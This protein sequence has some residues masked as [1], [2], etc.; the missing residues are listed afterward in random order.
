MIRDLTNK[1]TKLSTNALCKTVTKV[2][3]FKFC[4]YFNILSWVIGAHQW[5]MKM[6]IGYNV[7]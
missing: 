7:K 3:T 6:G 4:E 2:K 1:S 5:L